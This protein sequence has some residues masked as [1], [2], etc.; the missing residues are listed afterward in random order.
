MTFISGT[1]FRFPTLRLSH[2]LDNLLILLTS[3]QGLLVTL[4]S[5]EN[6]LYDSN[7]SGI[8]LIAH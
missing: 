4:L 6:P 2:I 8:D 5:M 3:Y 1:H 7:S